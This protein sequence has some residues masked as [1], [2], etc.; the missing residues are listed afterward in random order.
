MNNL[1]HKFD[2]NYI[3][4]QLNRHEIGPANTTSN[5]IVRSCFPTA[6]SF[7]GF[8]WAKFTFSGLQI[9]IVILESK[10]EHQIHRILKIG[11]HS[12]YKKPACVFLRL[13]HWK[14]V[15]C[16]PF[17]FR[18][19]NGTRKLEYPLQPSFVFPLRKSTYERASTWHGEALP[20]QC[21]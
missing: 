14:K 19:G 10:S 8:M 12:K 6:I 17:F 4:N 11:R 7:E 18:L 3:L 9:T 21:V 16:V 20:S 13:I 15:V 1:L 5:S 2:T